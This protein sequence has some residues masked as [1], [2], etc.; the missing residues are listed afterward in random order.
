M[1]VGTF[2]EYRGHPAYSNSPS[3]MSILTQVVPKLE[4]KIR[5]ESGDILVK[6]ELPSSLSVPAIAHVLCG[7]GT[8]GDRAGSRMNRFAR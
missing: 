3:R 5:V 8:D 4:E 2:N 6:L 7:G 1:A